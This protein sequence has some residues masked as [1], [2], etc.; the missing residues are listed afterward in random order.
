M[1]ITVQ[2]VRKRYGPFAQ[3]SA[4]VHAFAG[5]LLAHRA[6]EHCGLGQRV[7]VS[8]LEALVAQTDAHFVTMAYKGEAHGR[9]GDHRVVRRLLRDAQ[10]PPRYRTR[11][12]CAGPRFLRAGQRWDDCAKPFRAAGSSGDGRNG[13]AHDVEPGKPLLHSSASER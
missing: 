5:T 7:D 11:T 9:R 4:G 8:I 6:R 13:T 3:L 1:S 2:N 12:W 10:R